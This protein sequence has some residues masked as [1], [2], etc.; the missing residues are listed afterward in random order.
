LRDQEGKVA[1]FYT[2]SGLRLPPAAR[3]GAGANSALPAH[4]PRRPGPACSSLA[5]AQAPGRQARRSARGPPSHART[6]T[7]AR[8]A[9]PGNGNLSELSLSL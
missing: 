4:H 6:V 2:G 9:L 8:R 1:K 7:R 5:H 3:G